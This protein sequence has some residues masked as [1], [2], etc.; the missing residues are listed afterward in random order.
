MRGKLWPMASP[1]LVVT[2]LLTCCFVFLSFIPYFPIYSIPI[3]FYSVIL[4]FSLFS[5]PGYCFPLCFSLVCFEVP[6]PVLLLYSPYLIPS[7]QIQF[8][9]IFRYWHWDLH[10]GP[11]SPAAYRTILLERSSAHPGGI[12][13]QPVCLWCS[14]EAAGTK[15]R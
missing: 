11:C 7:H 4:L 3:P 12:C 6:L 1:C 15:R 9:L 14:D 2:S 10:P 5:L 13:F 8:H